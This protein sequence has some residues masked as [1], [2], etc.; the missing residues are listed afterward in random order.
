[1]DLIWELG[2][3]LDNSIEDTRAKQEGRK[4]HEDRIC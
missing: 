4:E 2:Y 3:E 1:M